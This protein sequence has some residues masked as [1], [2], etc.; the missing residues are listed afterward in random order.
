V[1][2]WAPRIPVFGIYPTAESLALQ[3]LLV[4]LLMFAIVWLQR[5]RFLHVEE[6]GASVR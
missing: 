5:R 3:G 4:A 2:E 6:R 1:L